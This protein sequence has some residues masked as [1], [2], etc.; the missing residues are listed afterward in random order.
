MRTTVI[1]SGSW[2]DKLLRPLGLEL[3]LTVMKIDVA[4]WQLTDHLDISTATSDSGHHSNH[5]SLGV[6]I[7]WDGIHYYGLPSYEYPGL[8][9]VCVWYT[10]IS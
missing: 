2:T 6:F 1:I 4:Y 10:R 5:R 8:V 7:L 3:P 9:K